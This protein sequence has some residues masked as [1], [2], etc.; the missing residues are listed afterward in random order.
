MLF[1]HINLVH[2]A[3]KCADASR[4]LYRV[5]KLNV[6]LQEQRAVRPVDINLRDAMVI[7]EYLASRYYEINSALHRGDNG[8]LN[9]HLKYIERLKLALNRLK[10][11]HFHIGAVRRGIDLDETK[12]SRYIAGSVVIEPAFTSTTKK[13]ELKQLN[14]N[15]LFVIE[16]RGQGVDVSFLQWKKED[17]VIFPP[18]TKFLITNVSRQ[19]E[20]FVISMTAL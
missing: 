5:Q 16:S 13:H 8:K 7:Y 10:K 17:E 2:A 11:T 4:K 19:S 1:T 9:G 14:E 3:D 15:T 12:R 6:H 20:Q 18:G